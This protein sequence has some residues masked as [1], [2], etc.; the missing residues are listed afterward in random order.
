VYRNGEKIREWVYDTY[1]YD[2]DYKTLEEPYSYEIAAVYYNGEGARSAKSEWVVFPLTDVF[3][4]TDGHSLSGDGYGYYRITVP[5]SVP[6]PY[7]L[8]LYTGSSNTIYR[9]GS[10]FGSYYS[11]DRTYYSVSAGDELILVVGDGGW[12]SGY[13]YYSY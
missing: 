2:T 12:Y 4:S 6:Y 9:N 10:N 7:Y 8:M 5:S 13:L 11:G 3:S 1:Y